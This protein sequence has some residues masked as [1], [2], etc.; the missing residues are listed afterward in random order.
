MVL[1][2]NDDQ[3]IEGVWGGIGAFSTVLLKQKFENVNPLLL[4]LI[5]FMAM[6]YTRKVGMNLYSEYKKNNDIAQRGLKVEMKPLVVGALLLMAM[7]L[8]LRPT[9]LMDNLNTTGTLILFIAMMSITIGV[10]FKKL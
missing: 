1:I 8:F 5:G 2:L 4:S 10:Y 6:W 9:N 7:F 3:F